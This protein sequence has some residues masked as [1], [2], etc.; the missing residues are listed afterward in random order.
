M[1]AASP[2]AGATGRPFSTSCRVACDLHGVK[3]SSMCTSIS[4]S[5]LPATALQPVALRAVHAAARCPLPHCNWCA[6]AA[7]AR[8]AGCARQLQG[9]LLIH[10]PRLHACRRTQGGGARACLR[11]PRR[12]QRCPAARARVRCLLAVLPAPPRR[13]AWALPRTRQLLHRLQQARGRRLPRR[14][15]HAAP[16]GRRMDAQARG[17]ESSRQ[18][19]TLQQAWRG[20]LVRR[21]ASR[22]GPPAPCPAA[23][24]RPSQPA[25]QPPLTAAAPAQ[26]QSAAGRA[27]STGRAAGCAAPP[28]HTCRRQWGA[29]RRGRGAAAWLT[30][31]RQQQRARM[32][33]T[34]AGG[35]SSGGAVHARNRACGVAGQ[36]RPHARNQAAQ[37]SAARPPRVAVRQQQVLAVDGK[38]VLL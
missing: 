6:L 18:P 1:S 14:A 10:P 20:A 28:L 23:A 30:Q 16:A 24:P 34:H 38:Q 22:V 25:S 21:A 11:A 15:G 33:H 4:A 32:Q 5:A 12:T 3:R 7:V 13:P 17:G 35:A 9:A 37:R 36:Q 29:G 19:W 8:V 2:P 31:T 27:R 26:S